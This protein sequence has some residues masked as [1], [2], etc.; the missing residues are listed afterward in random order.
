MRENI[1][2]SNPRSRGCLCI[3]F[4]FMIILLHFLP[5]LTVVQGSLIGAA[6]I[7]HGDF[8]WDPSLIHNVNGSLYLHNQTLLLA[9]TINTMEPDLIL[10][11]TPHGV[12]LT[13]DFAVS[14]STNGSGFALLGED[15]HNTSYPSYTVPMNFPLAPSVSADLVKY[16]RSSNVTGILPWADSEPFPLRWGEIIPLAFFSSVLNNSYT[17]NTPQVLVWSQPLR[18]YNASVAMIPELLEMGN[19]LYTYFQQLTNV[20]TFVIVSADLA[21]THLN[22]VQP[23][24]PCP[25]AVTFDT[26]CQVWASS[27]NET[28]L[29]ETAAGVVDEALSCGYTGMVILHGMIRDRTP[30]FQPQLYA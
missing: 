30:A 18:R 23:Y 1:I 26:A 4:S 28:A 2:F 13:N 24:P 21:H 27:L 16:L 12:A 11:I 17:S 15:L 14:L 8:V 9:E 29:L 25:C 10:L 3:L 20:R 7:P 6:V 5:F 19:L 22:P